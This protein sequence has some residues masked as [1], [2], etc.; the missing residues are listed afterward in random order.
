MG[1]LRITGG[2]LKGRN[3]TILDE[4]EA[5]YTSGKVRAAIFNLL[6]DVA[7]CRI[8]D[9]FAG[10]GSFTAEAMSRGAASATCV[11]QDRT[12]VANLKNNLSSLS[13]DRDCL[14]LNM[15]VRYAVPFLHEGRHDYDIVFMDPPYERGLVLETMVLLKDNAVYHKDTLFIVESSKRERVNLNLLNQWQEITTKSYGDTVIRL[16]R[17]SI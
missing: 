8:L 4:A 5:R 6:G 17:T 13:I 11:E 10:A 12:I 9:L 14:V 3:I 2:T 1:K 7:G 15:D 16:F